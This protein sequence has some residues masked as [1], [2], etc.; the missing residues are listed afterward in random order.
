VYWRSRIRT[1]SRWRSGFGDPPD[2]NSPHWRALVAK[3]GP[4]HNEHAAQVVHDDLVPPPAEERVYG[5]KH[6]VD[7]E[8]LSAWS[9]ELVSSI[10]EG[11]G[12]ANSISR[13]ARRITERRVRCPVARA[14]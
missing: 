3:G 10:Y 13:R 6:S 9:I 12:V 4:A 1:A 14:S 8:E 11:K 7:T 5:V 2:T